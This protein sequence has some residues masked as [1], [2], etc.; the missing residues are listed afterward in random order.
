MIGVAGGLPWRLKA[1]MKKFRAITMGKPLVM[2]RKTFE[3][4]GR[5]LDGRD[6][7]VVTRQRDFSAAGVSIATSIDE[8]LKLAT[9]ATKSDPTYVDAFDTL[10][11]IYYLRADYR[12]AATALREFFHLAYWLASTFARGAKPAPDAV[13][14]VEALPR[15]AQVPATTLG[16]TS[17]R[18]MGWPMYAILPC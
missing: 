11:W 12:S 2:G 9:Q 3:S 16:N 1:D 7:I 14:R 15:L 18:Y 6:V 4:I 10:G 13:F 8:A 5:V 17:S